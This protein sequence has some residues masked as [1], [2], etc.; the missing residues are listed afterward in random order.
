MIKNLVEAKTV[1]NWI[2]DD[3][4]LALIDVRETA[5][6]TAGHPLFSISIPFSEFE[7]NVEKLV[8]N[9]KVRLVLFDNNNGVSEI[10]YK[11]A[12]N[13][14]FINI[15]ILKD[16]VEGWIK[17]KFRL[18]DG[19]NVPS[20]SFGE[21][22]VEKFNTPYITASQLSKKQKEN[23]DIV[24]LDGR[25][26][27]E[28][29]KMSIPGSICCPNAEIPY[30]ISELIKSS[31]TEIIINCAGRTR[32]IIGTQTLI[33]FGIK[34]KVYAL[35]NGTQG[36]FLNNF[37]LDHGKT[38]FFYK[39]PKSEKI[40]ELREKIVNLLENKVKIIDFNQ[41][42][43]LINDKNITTYVFD[44]RTN[45][46]QKNKLSKLRNVPGGQLVQAT[47][48]YIGV[49]KSHVIIFDD[50]DLV[51]AG[52]TALWLKK[53]SYHCYV[54]NES[55]K[56]IKNLNLKLEVNFKTIPLNLINL[57]NFKNLQDTHI[58]DIRNSIDYCK[59]RIKKSVWTNRFIIKKMPHHI[60]SMILVTNDLPKASLI[61]SDLQEKDPGYMVQVYNWNDKDVEHCLDYID[62]T[63]VEL[64][65]TFIDFNF[66]THLRHQGNKE[67]ARNYLK[68]ETD[69]IKKMDE[70][71]MV[72]F[73]SLL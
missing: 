49:L 62:S 4:E 9:K 16:G 70:E 36:W 54:V 65:Q 44:V 8:P 10:I 59:K 67:H 57:E 12:K 31:D 55:P 20:K 46:N 19:I 63:K 1:K 21:L 22:I 60:K 27:D 51:R 42:Q 61:V 72:F 45:S 34:N 26:F 18:F 33:D 48:K 35:E 71:E 2:S 56:K 5:Q 17:S 3:Q 47:D 64:D 69:L 40:N 14:K 15:F 24:I 7:I 25:P 11:Q 58:F 53:M 6:H 13:L 29:N 30:R 66:H 23:K 37:K 43:N 52:M 28:Y 32:S 50:G 73:R 38:K 68:W 41:A 39:T